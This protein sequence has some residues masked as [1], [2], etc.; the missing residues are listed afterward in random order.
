M[1]SLRWCLLFWESRFWFWSS[2][3]REPYLLSN[4][5]SPLMRAISFNWLKLIRWSAATSYLSSTFVLIWV[6]ISQLSTFLYS[7]FPIIVSS[8]NIDYYRLTSILWYFNLV[9]TDPSSFSF[10]LSSSLTVLLDDLN[11]VSFDFIYASIMFIYSAWSHGFFL[12]VWNLCFYDWTTKLC[13]NSSTLLPKI[14][15]CREIDSFW[16]TSYVFTW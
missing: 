12:V 14:T 7:L 6:L 1:A 5:C 3:T 16:T 11:C 8:V 9:N 13:F 4:W 2:T 10:S 15:N